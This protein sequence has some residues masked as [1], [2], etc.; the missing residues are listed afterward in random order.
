MEGR[1][2]KSEVWES[3]QLRKIGSSVLEELET[4]IFNIKTVPR[5][6]KLRGSE[7]RCC[8]MGKNVNRVQKS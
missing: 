1:L 6:R 4:Y 2:K 8:F 5:N 7:Q 3:R